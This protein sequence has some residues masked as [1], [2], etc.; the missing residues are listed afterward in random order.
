ME[1]IK[2]RGSLWC[3]NETVNRRIPQLCFTLAVL[4]KVTACVRSGLSLYPKTQE[5]IKVYLPVNLSVFAQRVY[6]YDIMQPVQFTGSFVHTVHREEP[7]SNEVFGPAAA[8][9]S[10]TRAAAAAAQLAELYFFFKR[11]TPTKQDF[12]QCLRLWKKY[13]KLMTHDNGISKKDPQ[14]SLSVYTQAQVVP[15]FWHMIIFFTTLSSG[16]FVIH[17]TGLH[18]INYTI[19]N[20]HY[21]KS[22]HLWL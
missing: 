5:C 10:C 15:R 3:F 8:P 9:T 19:R 16:L 21:M 17:T 4:F 12:I 11:H 18:T 7:G 20:H 1:C 22:G 14:C 6:I 13:D 2:W